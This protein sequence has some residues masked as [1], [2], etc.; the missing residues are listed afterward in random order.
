MANRLFAAST[1]PF[2]FFFTGVLNLGRAVGDF[3]VE[4]AYARLKPRLTMP[5]VD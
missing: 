2:P 5:A 4:P 3:A 1:P